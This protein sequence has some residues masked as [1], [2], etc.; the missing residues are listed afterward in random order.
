MPVA[1]AAG[2]LCVDKSSA[3]RLVDGYPLVVPEVNGAPCARVARARPDRRQPELL[4]DP[5]HLR[6]EAAPRRGRSR[7]R[8][9]LDLPVRLRRRSASDDGAGR[10]GAGRA[11]PRDGLVVGGRRVG[12][13]GEA[14]RRDAQ[15]PR[16]SRPPDLGDVRPCPRDG[17]AL[18]GRLGRAR[19]AALARRRCRDPARRTERPRPRPPRVPDACSRGGRRRGARRPHPPRHAPPRTAWRST[20]RATTCARAQRSTRSRSPSSCSTASQPPDND[21]RTRAERGTATGS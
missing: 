17:R 4:H 12:R 18:R 2:A 20:S 9:G 14:P 8:Q 10:R 3:Y 15:D 6:P 5:A 21:A 1:S 11:R 19:G 13:G 7:A 16:A